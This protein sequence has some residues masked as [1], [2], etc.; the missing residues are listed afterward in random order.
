M[1]NLE[2]IEQRCIDLNRKLLDSPTYRPIASSSWVCYAMAIDPFDII[3]EEEYERGSYHNLIESYFEKLYDDFT[4]LEVEMG[5][6]P[7]KSFEEFMGNDY[8]G[9]PLQT[10]DDLL[11]KIKN[12]TEFI[13]KLGKKPW[14]PDFRE[15]AIERENEKLSQ[16]LLDV[17]LENYA[18]TQEEIAYAEL[19]KDY[20]CRYCALFKEWPEN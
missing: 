1:T 12:L 14:L 2:I 16:L 10:Q 3:S 6:R 8:R 9:K 20:D 17:K 11:F 7:A 13:T 19:Y 18:K 5:L 4:Q 15:S